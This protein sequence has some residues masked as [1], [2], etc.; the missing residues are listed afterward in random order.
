[1]VFRWNS[2]FFRLYTEVGSSSLYQEDKK[3]AA[4]RSD[5]AAAVGKT[6]ASRGYI[7]VTKGV[8]SIIIMQTGQIYFIITL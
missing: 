1:M 3:A 5:G 2:A 8:M 4:L 6:A 7:F